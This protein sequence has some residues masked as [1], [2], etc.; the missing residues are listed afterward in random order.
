MKES[1]SEEEE[2]GISK[3]RRRIRVD[4][5][6]KEVK[7]WKNSSKQQEAPTEITKTKEEI[8]LE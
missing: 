2:I 6:N 3:C 5:T 1:S 8:R 7:E 4:I